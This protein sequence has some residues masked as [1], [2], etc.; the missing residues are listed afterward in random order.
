MT[1]LMNLEDIMSSEINQSQKNNY[2]MIPFI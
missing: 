2:Y 1:I